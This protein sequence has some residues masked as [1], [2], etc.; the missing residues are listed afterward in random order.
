MTDIAFG[1]PLPNTADLHSTDCPASPT[2]PTE[3]RMAE[4]QRQRDY[5]LTVQPCMQPPRETCTRRTVCGEV[6]PDDGD[7]TSSRGLL[8][9]PEHCAPARHANMHS[10]AE[11]FNR[12]CHS[13][14]HRRPCW[15]HAREPFAG[16]QQVCRHA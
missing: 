1:K 15:H 4:W 6:W 16:A 11:T 13:G 10:A 9:Q 2:L 12:T 3:P 8:S 14:E 7:S 5:T